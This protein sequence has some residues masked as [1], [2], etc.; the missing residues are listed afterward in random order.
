MSVPPEPEQQSEAAED[1]LRIPR[2]G[3]T[4]EQEAAARRLFAE[5]QADLAA[6]EEQA[7]QGLAPKRTMSVKSTERTVKVKPGR[8]DREEQLKKAKQS[9]NGNAAPLR[10][11][12]RQRRTAPPRPPARRVVR[13]GGKDPPDSDD[14]EPAGGRLSP[15]DEL[16][17][18]QALVVALIMREYLRRAA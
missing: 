8:A 2:H 17:W 11:P 7:R 4:P 16:I 5:I 18:Q 12:Q 3:K 1:P 13:T 14:P 10:D 9:T 15:D 6:Q